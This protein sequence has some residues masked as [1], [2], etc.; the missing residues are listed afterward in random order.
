MEVSESAAWWLIDA[1]DFNRDRLARLDLK[2]LDLVRIEPLTPGRYG[3]Q[4]GD[5]VDVLEQFSI[6]DNLVKAA[7]VRRYW[8]AVERFGDVGFFDDRISLRT[9]SGLPP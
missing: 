8:R 9:A 2:G 6:L 5:T 4:F 3:I 1:P 7:V